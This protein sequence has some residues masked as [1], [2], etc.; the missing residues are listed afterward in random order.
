MSGTGSATIDF[1]GTPGANRT[2]VAVADTNILAG[3]LAE[4]WMMADS[5]AN[6]NVTEHTIVPI[7]LTCAV[8]AGVGFTIYAVSA[9]ILTST[10]KVRWVW[11]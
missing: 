2:S 4:A 9:W 8:V 3:S 11:S 10:F 1:G 6:H 7:K 5:T